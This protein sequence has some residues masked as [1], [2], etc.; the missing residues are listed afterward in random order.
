VGEMGN[1]AEQGRL[2]FSTKVSAEETLR[3]FSERFR[4]HRFVVFISA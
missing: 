3:F 2:K 1:H 4:Y